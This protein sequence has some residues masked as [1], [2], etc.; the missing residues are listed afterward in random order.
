M[1][2]RAAP[3][4]LTSLIALGAAAPAVARTYDAPPDAPAPQPAPWYLDSAELA[5][6]ER[7]ARTTWHPLYTYAGDEDA[8]DFAER[9]GCAPVWDGGVNRYVPACN[10]H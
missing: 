8:T 1:P 7:Y 5:P 6:Y 4:I 9:Y 10:S 2:H 3:L